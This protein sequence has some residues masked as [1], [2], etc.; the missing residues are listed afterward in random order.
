MPA[1]N[2]ITLCLIIAKLSL[3]LL[4]IKSQWRMK[5]LGKLLASVRQ[6]WFGCAGGG[7]ANMPILCPIESVD[8]LVTFVMQLLQTSRWFRRRRAVGFDRAEG[9]VESNCS[10]SS[11]LSRSLLKLH[12]KGDEGVHLS[13]GQSIVGRLVRQHQEISRDFHSSCVPRERLW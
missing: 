9:A 11:K 2:A 12:D 7:S 10:S 8:T 4:P 13:T 3:Y 5:N 6:R 1:G